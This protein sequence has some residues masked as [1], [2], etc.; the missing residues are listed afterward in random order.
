MDIEKF[1][2]L[3]E[4]EQDEMVQNY[5]IFLRNYIEGNN[6]CDIYKIFNFY[7]KFCYDIT[8]S[9]KPS[10]IVL[11]HKDDFNLYENELLNS[12]LN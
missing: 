3:C 12:S 1:K 9:L 11:I 2:V 7:V 8:K 5:G 6:S 4:T 10:I